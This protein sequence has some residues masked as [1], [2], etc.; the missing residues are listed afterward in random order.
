MSIEVMKQ[1]LECVERC[2]AI[3]GVYSW[4]GVVDSL[5][6]ATAEAA[7]VRPEQAE[8]QEP[9]AAA[10]DE[11]YRQGIQDERTSEANIGIAGFNAKVGPARQN[12]YGSCPPQRQPLTDEEIN[13][14]MK[15]EL[16]YGSC[17]TLDD[18]A[19]ARA[20]EAAHGIEAK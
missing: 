5:R 6:K 8:Q 11:G 13:A 19:F 16:G 4:S 12:P 14:L 20:V 3:D 2:D 17:P 10:W 18:I 1:W 15:T 9:V 7:Q